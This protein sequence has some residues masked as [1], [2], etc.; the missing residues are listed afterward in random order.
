M[1]G[2]VHMIEAIHSELVELRQ[3]LRKLEETNER[4]KRMMTVVSHSIETLDKVRR[5][6]MA[7]ATRSA[8]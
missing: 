4:T 2:E 8:K 1:A 7:K 5:Y 6:E 3:E